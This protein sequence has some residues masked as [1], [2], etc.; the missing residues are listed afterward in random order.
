[1]ADESKAT[2][3]FDFDAHRESA[4]AKYGDCRALYEKFAETAKSILA[5]TLNGAHVKYLSIE[6]RTK[7]IK[8]FGDKAVKPSELDPT[9]PKYLDPLKNITDMAGIRVITFLPRTIEDVCKH[10]EREFSV[11]EKVD[12]AAELMDEGKFGYKSV[13]FLVQM[14]SSRTQL[15]GY[16]PYSGLILEIQV[17]TILQH[18]WAEME[19]DIQYKSTV[20]IPILIKRRFIALAGLLEIADR[21]FQTLQDEY[22]HKKQQK[23]MQIEEFIV[24]LRKTLTEGD[25]GDR[26][27]A[28]EALKDLNLWLE[29]EKSAGDRILE[30][31]K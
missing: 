13:H 31:L 10:V 6:A 16:Q 30:D 15:T 29:S 22:E 19:H 17:R 27:Y 3:P 9:K 28:I 18:A 12:K 11:L 20:E 14:P 25:P 24:Q 4:V 21:E 8:S 23:D 7:S 2:S 5:D 1:M 26:E